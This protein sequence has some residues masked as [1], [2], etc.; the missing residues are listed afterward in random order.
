MLYPIMP[1]GVVAGKAM[2]DGGWG[3]TQIRGRINTRHDVKIVY[4]AVSH[5]DDHGHLAVK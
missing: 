4:L 1:V 5:H 2:I 3:G